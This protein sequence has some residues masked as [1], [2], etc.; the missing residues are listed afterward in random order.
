MKTDPDSIPSFPVQARIESTNLCNAH[1]TICPRE[2]L[3]RVKGVMSFGD[4]EKLV[5]E[6]ADKGL[7]ELHLQGFGEPFIDKEITKKIRLAAELGIPELFLVTNASLIDEELAEEIVQSGLH[8]I[9]ISFYGTNYKEYESIH[10]PLKY[11]HVRKN[12]KALARA[13]RRLNSKTPR[14]A[15]QYIGSLHKFVK[16][17]LQWFRYALPQ[18]NIPH[19]YAYGKKYVKV[20]IDKQ[21]RRCPMVARPIL[22]VLWDGRVVPCCY[23]FNARYVLGNALKTSIEQVWNSQGYR[24]FRNSHRRKDFRAIP[25]C[26]NCDKLR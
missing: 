22:Q 4:F 1:C 9:K 7:R 23:D 25:M 19:N 13:K 5:R 17:T 26:L 20:K 12:I 16:F 8:R 24:R 10:E 14:I 2:L 15:V 21:D 3:T 11:E 6:C 18:F